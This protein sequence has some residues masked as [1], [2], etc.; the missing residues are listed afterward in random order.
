MKQ[1][2]MVLMT[3]IE[4]QRLRWCSQIRPLWDFM[5]WL[6]YP[7]SRNS[8]RPSAPSTAMA[9]EAKTMSQSRFWHCDCPRHYSGE[10]RMVSRRTYY[11][12]Q[13]EWRA[14]RFL[15][16]LLEGSPLDDVPNDPEVELAADDEILW[17][18][19][20]SDGGI[21]DHYLHL[22]TRLRH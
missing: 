21:M 15:A 6:K 17:E 16:P 9:S 11:R 19:R 20:G 3:R 10:L 14:N 13:Q 1:S 5:L 4:D 7:K 8:A 18:E 22:I 2:G 12:H